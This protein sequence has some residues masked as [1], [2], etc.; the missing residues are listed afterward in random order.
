M[1][2]AGMKGEDY[3]QSGKRWRLRLHE[4]GGKFHEVHAHHNAETYL[5]AYLAAAGITD[6]RKT[7]LFRSASGRGQVASVQ[8]PVISRPV[9]WS[10]TRGRTCPPARSMEKCRKEVS[11]DEPCDA[12]CPYPDGRRSDSTSEAPGTMLRSLPASTRGWTSEGP[13]G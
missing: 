5:D 12:R 9:C 11:P 13:E 3:H 7:P 10:A 4:K 1:A 6:D 2:V 8:K